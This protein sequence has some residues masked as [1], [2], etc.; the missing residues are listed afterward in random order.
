MVKRQ[1]KQYEEH[2]AKM[3]ARSLQQSTAGR[4][5]AE[6]VQALPAIKNKRR[7]AA[8]NKSFR[9]FCETYMADLFP[10]AWSD[11]H[12]RVLS[13]TE[14]AVLE[15]GLFALAM[16]RG[17]GKTTIAEC[18][19]MWALLYGHRRF[20]A[21][22]GSD[23]GSADQMLDDIKVT[24]ET[25]EILLEDFRLEI[26]P[27]VALDGIALRAKGQ[28]YDGKRT[29]TTWKG[30]SVVMPTIDGSTASGAVLRVSGITG[31][32]RGMK[33]VTTQGEAIRP[34][35][36]VV[37]DPQTDES[38]RSI[39]QS[40]TRESILAGA[41]LGLAGPGK[42]IA[43]IMP[44]TV[45]RP[46][47]MADNILDTDKHPEW[48]GERTKMV[49]AWPKAVKLWERYAE[50]RVQSLREHDDNRLANEF[51]KAN[52]DK[53]D[54][55]SK[56][57]WPARFSDDELSAIQHAM[58]LKLRDETAF[59]AEYQNE[60][61]V[62]DSGNLE[63][64]TEDQVLSHC[65]GL[66]PMQVPADAQCVTAF[67][68]VQEHSFWWTVCA[69]AQEMRGWVLQYGVFPEQGRGYVTN[70]K[71][72]RK[73]SSRYKGCTVQDAWSKG[74]DELLD[75]LVGM[76]WVDPDGNRHG[77][78]RIL[79]DQNYHKSQEVIYATCRK[80]SHKAMLLPA[81]GH[82][83]GARTKPMEEWKKKRGERTG[84]GWRVARSDKGGRMVTFDTNHWKSVIAT[85]IM[86][87]SGAPTLS[88]Y[89]RD[90][91]AHRCLADHLCAEYPV[92]TIGRQRELDE[93]TLR[94]GRDNHWFDGVVGCAVAAS[95]EGIG[96]SAASGARRPALRR[97]SAGP[98]MTVAERQ[99]AKRAEKAASSGH[100]ADGSKRKSLA[101]IQREKRAARGR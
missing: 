13:K 67:I 61:L 81:H 47:D 46:G 35:L 80:S 100:T 54:A 91:A 5:I 51:Y 58:N 78:D 83:I 12:L 36:V 84:P 70:R 18:A 71:L 44:C 55:G 82:Y 33:T 6:Q 57:G 75:L 24:I 50:L 34:D 52:R 43:G 11:D 87:A 26:Y 101:E 45:I 62:D 32:I 93:W 7:R 1:G 21:L 17:S 90:P 22:I 38:A 28:I 40:A 79:I 98:R 2:K 19:C 86:A 4:D 94:P 99:A 42:K 23:Q 66:P 8:C 41:V 3:A 56:V 60:P 76:P 92:R 74:L 30:Q 89:G 37:D 14:R 77:I 72:Q 31:R 65:N 25:N 29:H 16:P 88:L 95:V 97:R 39:T 96:I 53:M 15:G 27:I 85:R 64:I 10:L 9:K 63:P 69:W 73:L 48:S 20:V 49:Y 59:F 68:D